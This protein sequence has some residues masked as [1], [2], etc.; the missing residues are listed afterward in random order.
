MKLKKAFKDTLPIFISYF[1]L[2]F[3]FG[4]LA[5]NQGL[6][7]YLAILM[8]IV[9]YSGSLQFLLLTMYQ[10]FSLFDIFIT[11]ILLNF[12]QFFYSL[13]FLDRYK[14][15]LYKIF[16]LTDETFAIL[17]NKKI[18]SKYELYVSILNHIYWITGTI[19]G[20]IFIHYI[21]FKLKGLDFIL[22]AL[23]VVILVEDFLKTKNFFP[24]IL[25]VFSYSIFQIIGLE[26]SLIFSIIFAFF[27]ITIRKSYA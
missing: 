5:V 1:S 27:T 23:F 16:A 14:N 18:D 13:T 20:V 24:I 9:I 26:N 25:G 11:S 12:R 19:S 7:P 4:V 2:S 6:N 3:S 21:D 22:I 15:S 8:S 17:S 10:K